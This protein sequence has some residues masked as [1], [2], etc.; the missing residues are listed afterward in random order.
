[1]N[2]I[3]QK[4]TDKLLLAF[5]LVLLCSSIAMADN[6]IQQE[7]MSFETCLKVIKI[8]E[9]K[10]S[11]GSETSKGPGQKRTALF[12]LSDGILKIICDGEKNS[13]TVSTNEN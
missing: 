4:V 9:D 2:G 10:L 13:I 3:R 6:I 1:M 8:S 12:K 5:G 11:V 7:K